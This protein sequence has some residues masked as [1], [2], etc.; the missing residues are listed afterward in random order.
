M[1]DSHKLKSLI[2]MTIQNVLIGCMCKTVLDCQP[3][4]TKLKKKNTNFTLDE[5]RCH[6]V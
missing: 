5:I 2:D 4:T 3:T 1:F 6:N